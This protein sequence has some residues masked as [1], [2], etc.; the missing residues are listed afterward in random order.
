MKEGI[1]HLVQCHCVLPQY[2]KRKDPVF[3]KFL[4]FSILDNGICTPKLSQCNNCG[5]LHNVVDICKSELLSGRDESNTIPNEID[6]G[7]SISDKLKHILESN[8]CD[9]TLW[10]QA[11][12]YEENKLWGNKI[13]L[14]K[15]EIKNNI[16]VK[17]LLFVDDKKFK[18]QTETFQ[19]T[20]GLE[21]EN[22]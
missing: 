12:F 1:R 10:E 5:Q 15:D 7:M 4:V 20:I 6:I 2:R 18:I 14:S 16:Q 3:H 19:E 8:N 9:I 13:I 21:D 22:I 17:Y 11:Q